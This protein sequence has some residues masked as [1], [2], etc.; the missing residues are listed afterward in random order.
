MKVCYGKEAR[1]A[2]NKEKEA[3]MPF[4]SMGGTHISKINPQ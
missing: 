2:W 1:V 4:S 3:R